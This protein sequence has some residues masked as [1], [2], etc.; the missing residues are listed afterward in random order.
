VEKQSEFAAGSVDQIEIQLD[1]L[2]E[3]QKAEHTTSGDKGKIETL[4]T[5]LRSAKPTKDHKCADSG[6]ITLRLK[7]DGTKL[8]LGIL[9][10]HDAQFYEFRAYH[11]GRYDIFRVPRAPFLKAIEAFGV[12]KLNQ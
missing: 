1:D 6:K 12:G 10:G 3:H 2:A 7:K 8:E 9:A 4:L 5:I 11:N